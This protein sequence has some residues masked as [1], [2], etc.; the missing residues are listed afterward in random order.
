MILSHLISITIACII[1]RIIGDPENW[2]HPVKWIGSF[3]SQLEK[4]WN[5]GYNGRFTGSVML[6]VV[7]VVS[8]S[9]TFII[10]RFSYQVH[11]IV[12]IIIESIIISTTIAQKSLKKAA[13]EVFTPLQNGDIDEA[14]KK[15]SY[16]VG[17]DTDKL[18]E[19]EVVRAT[20]ET[21]VENISDGVTAPIFWAFIGG[22]PL[23]I[24][25][26]A[27]NTCDS[28]VGYKNERFIDFGWASAK[29]DDIVNWIPSRLTAYMM[30]FGIKDAFVS[31]KKALE[32][33]FRDARKHPSPNSGWL[34]AAFAALHGVQLGGTNTYK[35]MISIRAK[36]GDP[37]CP[38]TI[39]HI[40]KAIT[41][42]WRSTL[43]FLITL[44]L[45]G[46]IFYVAFAWFKSTIFI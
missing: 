45:G 39:I 42:L 4:R 31:R 19:G 35:G 37:I 16:I 17:R 11:V 43:L 40:K 1:D 46:I 8:F 32:L 5:R 34:E 10:V 41:I 12:G 2:P 27:I 38:L 18:N 20:V 3:I 23:A 28:M 13:I 9:I 21:V 15:L 22:A 7:L 29:A 30:V 24:V 6:L 14:R 44:W 33:L 36:M 25:Y 26:R